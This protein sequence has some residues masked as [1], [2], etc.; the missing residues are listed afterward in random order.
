[1]CWFSCLNAGL[2]S[3]HRISFPLPQ[4]LKRKG[5]HWTWLL[6][7]PW[8]FSPPPP[9]RPG[10]SRPEGRILLQNLR[11]FAAIHPPLPSRAS[12]THPTQVSAG[13]CPSLHSL[14]VLHLLRDLRSLPILAY[15]LPT[16]IWSVLVL[17]P[18][19]CSLPV[20]SVDTFQA[21][22]PRSY[23]EGTDGFYLVHCCSPNSWSSA[24]SIA[25]TEQTF[26]MVSLGSCICGIHLLKCFSPCPKPTYRSPST[27]ATSEASCDT[28][29]QPW[30]VGPSGRN[31]TTNSVLSHTHQN[32]CIPLGPWLGRARVITLRLLPVSQP[33]P[34]VSDLSRSLFRP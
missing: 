32:L 15:S 7:N 24:R 6:G 18:L 33:G 5:W 1:M 13:L 26:V 14:S 22:F 20:I 3:Y 21:V 30:C 17:T 8:S 12:A 28:L 9:L 29:P 10:F 23:C 4:V 16:R 31:A 34:R 27:P 25:D 19:V 11:D 2:D